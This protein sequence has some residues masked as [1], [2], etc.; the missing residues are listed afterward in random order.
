VSFAAFFDGAF[1]INLP[2][3]KDRRRAIAKELHKAGMP[4][5]ASKV[6]IFPAVRPKE[7]AGFPT[8]GVRGCFLSHLGLLLKA[9][10][11]G[12]RNV[13]VMEDDLVLSESIHKDLA[14]LR[15]GLEQPWDLAYFGHVE[16]VASCGVPQLLAFSQPL[17]TSHF[18]AIKEPALSRLIDFLEQVQLRSPGD[19]AGGPMHLD[20]ALTMFRQANPDLLTRIASPNLGWQ[21]PSRSDIHSNWFQQA[22]VFRHFY[23]I[24]RA[25]RSL[26]GRPDSSAPR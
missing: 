10:E 14:A 8:I 21:R 2:D 7:P 16:P 9:R 22:P 19:P 23:D 17:M 13:L 4:L 11:R 20:G 3:R 15:S 5:E 1:V 25:I 18:Y 6:E 12:C 24:A 26:K